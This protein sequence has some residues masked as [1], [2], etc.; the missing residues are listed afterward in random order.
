MSQTQCLPLYLGKQGAR[1]RELAAAAAEEEEDEKD[2]QN[3]E[4]GGEG[5]EV[6][7]NCS[8]SKLSATT[9]N[10]IKNLQTMDAM[11]YLSMVHQEASLLPKVF[12]KNT[13]ATPISKKTTTGIIKREKAMINHGVKCDY[14]DDD[15]LQLLPSEGSAATIYLSSRMNILPAQQMY[16]LPVHPNAWVTH[17]LADFSSLRQ[18]LEQQQATRSNS[19]LIP[20]PP[21]KDSGGW[22][23]F[24]LGSHEAE[25]NIG[26]Y[27]DDHN[28]DDEEEDGENEQDLAMEEEEEEEGEQLEWRRYLQQHTTNVGGGMKPSVS[29]LMQ[30]DQVMTRRVLSHLI[31]WVVEDNFPM[32]YQ[33]SLWIYALLARLEKPLHRNESALLRTILRTCCQLR[34]ECTKE[35]EE[36]GKTSV[37]PLLN[38]LIVIVGI[39]YEQGPQAMSIPNH[40]VFDAAISEKS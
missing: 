17:V 2:I 15:Y 36:D 29:L 24:C 38:V 31:S 7:E 32:S 39:Y 21:L 19:R 40:Q 13:T 1:K 14:G 16:Q 25:G 11:E 9:G 34:A 10:D 33:R 27:Y 5:V 23:E 37:L 4:E 20:L 6:N 3:L 28:V 30:M 8:Q 26:G 22:H 35:D 18:C 12:V